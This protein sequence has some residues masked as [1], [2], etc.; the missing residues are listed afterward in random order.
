[1]TKQLTLETELA[2]VKPRKSG[3]LGRVGREVPRFDEVDTELNEVNVLHLRKRD[4]VPFLLGQSL[5]L[6]RLVP[7]RLSWRVV[8]VVVVIV[9]C[10]FPRVRGRGSVPPA[11]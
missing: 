4:V 11:R 2:N 7:R 8:V 3:V 9:L 6:D 1:M 5:V 10:P